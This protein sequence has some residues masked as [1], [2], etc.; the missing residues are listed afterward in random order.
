MAFTFIKRNRVRYVYQKEPMNNMIP[1]REC[2]G[3]I[4]KNE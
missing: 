4:M 1:I 3:T 2:A